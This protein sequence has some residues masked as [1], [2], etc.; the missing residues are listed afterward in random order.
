MYTNIEIYEIYDTFS[1]MAINVSSVIFEKSQVGYL[2]PP[3]PQD[4]SNESK[5]RWL[6]ID[7]EIQTN[8]YENIFIFFGYF[9]K[10]LLI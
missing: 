8:I 2:C 6:K 3:P 10:L 9:W 1:I 5:R 7:E 4:I